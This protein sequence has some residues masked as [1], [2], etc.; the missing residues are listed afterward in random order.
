MSQQT[1]EKYVVPST[2]A[3][4]LRL[5]RSDAGLNMRELA[6]AAGID[7]GY[8]S[9]IESGKCDNLGSEKA[10]L[11]ASALKVSVEWLLL[12]VGSMQQVL[13]ETIDYLPKDN[14]QLISELRAEILWYKDQV[15]DARQ[16]EL[17]L[18]QIVETLSNLIAGP[19]PEQGRAEAAAPGAVPAVPASGALYKTH[20]S[21]T[22]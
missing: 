4:R 7:V 15:V 19:R 6:R 18:L 14:K 17:R 2:L 20:R 13:E 10:H 12:G 8:I 11:I 22:A 21:K 9:R 16:K 1:S 3:D 5:A